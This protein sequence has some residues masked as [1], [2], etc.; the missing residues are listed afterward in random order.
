ME[1]HVPDPY[2]KH[3]ITQPRPL[4]G[5]S[6]SGSIYACLNTIEISLG[7]VLVEQ[8]LIGQ[9]GLQAGERLIAGTIAGLAQPVVP[10]HIVAGNQSEVSRATQQGHTPVLPRKTSP[11]KNLPG[12]LLLQQLLYFSFM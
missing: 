10:D 12:H 4:A 7:I 2:P 1:L 5:G 11:L 6:S 8:R 9:N 3:R